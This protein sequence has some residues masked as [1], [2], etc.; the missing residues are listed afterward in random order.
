MQKASLPSN[1]CSNIKGI[2]YRKFFIAIFLLSHSYIFLDSSY[3]LPM[4][5]DKNTINLTSSN[6]PANQAMSKL[7]S[8]GTELF[9]LLFIHLYTGPTMKTGHQEVSHPT[10]E[11]TTHPA[12]KQGS[13]PSRFQASR[14]NTSQ[15]AI[16]P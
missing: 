8:P 1:K 13:Q 11:S 3:S 16:H 15:E 12:N 14:T 6:P 4:Q 9:L 10:R 5:S 2:L 7:N